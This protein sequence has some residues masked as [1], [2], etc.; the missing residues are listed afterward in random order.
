MAVLI[1]TMFS[2]FTL[3]FSVFSHAKEALMTPPAPPKI[4][5]WQQTFDHPTNIM[6]T[7]LTQAL[8]ITKAEF[9][10]YE[11]V[12]SI[13]MEQKRALST[14]SDKYEGDLDVAHFVSSEGR[15]K[16]AIPV[17]IPI[18]EGL[19]G[20]RVC[21]IKQNHQYKFSGINNIQDFIDKNITIGQQQDWLST[22]ILRGNG[23]QVQTSYKYSLL[24][25]QLQKQRFDCFLRGINEI[26]EELELHESANFVVENNLLFHY[27]FPVF[28]FVNEGRPDLAYRLTKGLTVL[29]HNGF[30]TKLL[31]NYYKDKLKTLHL[32]TRKVFHIENTFLPDKSLHSINT[33]PWLPL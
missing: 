29:Q 15:E 7:I 17:R 16:S 8:D 12:P 28:F 9:G 32:G 6:M 19:L 33:I 21:L 20:Y 10:D 26:T 18:L 22:K 11:I 27:P 24:F 3:T 23:I 4:I 13:P 31:E 5:V 30:L 14:L 1:F 25:G 2:I